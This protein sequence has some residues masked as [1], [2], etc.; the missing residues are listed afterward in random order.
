MERRALKQGATREEW[1][2]RIEKEKKRRAEKAEKLK[3]MGY[4]FDMP[5]VKA[6]SDVPVKPKAVEDIVAGAELNGV[7]ESQKVEDAG[8]EVVKDIQTVEAEPG[9]V[10][11]SE[12]NVTKKRPASGKTEVKKAIKKVKA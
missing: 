1:E 9:K 11:I 5:D 10:K 2:K 6:V 12:V 8:T 7:S 4:E 3:Q